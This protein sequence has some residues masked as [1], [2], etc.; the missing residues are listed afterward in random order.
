MLIR[1]AKSL[2]RLALDCQQWEMLD[3]LNHA[4][5][6][7]LRPGI[8]L[9]DPLQD[10]PTPPDHYGQLGAALALLILGGSYRDAWRLPIDVWLDLPKEQLGHLPFNRFLLLLIHD[11]LTSADARTEDCTP[12]LHGL[13]RCPMKQRYP[14]NNWT[15][16]RQLCRLIEAGPA[17]RQRRLKAFCAH[18]D[19]WTTPTGGFIDFPQHP[20]KVGAT[21]MTYHFKALFLAVVAAWFVDDPALTPRIQRL[22]N[23]ISLC[24]DDAGY[25]AGF[26]RST[27]ALFADGCLLAALILLGLGG[28]KEQTGPAQPMVDRL[29]GRLQAQRRPDGFYWLNP[30]GPTAGTSGWDDYMRLSVYNAWFA[31]VVAWALHRTRSRAR[32]LCLLDICFL[33]P[34][35]ARNPLAA[36]ENRPGSDGVVIS[37]D[38]AGII[39]VTSPVGLNLSVS[40]RGQPPQAFSRSSVEFRYAGGIPFHGRIGDQLVIP[41]PSRV[42]LWRLLECPALAGWTPVFQIRD[43]VY[44]L[45]DF[46]DVEWS[47]SRTGVT[48]TLSGSLMAL[49]RWPTGGVLN[50]MI[51]ALDWRLCHGAWARQEALKRERVGSIRGTLALSV[52]I[53]RPALTMEWTI[54]NDT[55]EPVTYL[56]PAGHALV[57][58]LLPNL[59]EMQSLGHASGR[60]TVQ[61]ASR[62]DVMISGSLESAVPHASGYCL[63]SSRLRGGENRFGVRLEW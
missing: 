41:P 26:G 5:Q 25:I 43:Q 45:T 22:L 8:G 18:I 51:G 17:T 28:D 12:I 33:D 39:R 15:L 59:W 42:P 56:N 40:S 49:A 61:R 57:T 60:L 13:A 55:Q 46:D 24:W 63:P 21:P 35:D 53:D 32:P 6:A 19:R 31:A 50:R 10:S 7:N 11:V 30:A 52:S 36:S 16:L 58:D 29:M 44:G 62:P 23:W 20:G 2:H 47:D 27:H 3:S 37:D 34:A 38:S 54:D 4:L 9:R 48:I 1:D 14:S